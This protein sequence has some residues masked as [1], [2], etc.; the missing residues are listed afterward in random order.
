MNPS[1]FDVRCEMSD[2]KTEGRWAIGMV[3]GRWPKAMVEGRWAKAMVEG[4]MGDGHGS[5]TMGDDEHDGRWGK[6]IQ[7]RVY[8]S[9]PQS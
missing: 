3:E 5:W 2:G 4:P 1:M 7:S 9:H 6:A 8:A